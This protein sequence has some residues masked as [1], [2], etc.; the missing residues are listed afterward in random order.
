MKF[1]KLHLQSGQPLNDLVDLIALTYRIKAESSLMVVADIETITADTFL[2][3]K[4][5]IAR[6]TEDRAIYAYTLNGDNLVKHPHSQYRDVCVAIDRLHLRAVKEHE[7][8]QR[9][10]ALCVTYRDTAEKIFSG[11]RNGTLFRKF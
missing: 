3:R 6:D 11:I 5:I 4:E 1:L 10:S 7:K 2:L 9:N 8:N